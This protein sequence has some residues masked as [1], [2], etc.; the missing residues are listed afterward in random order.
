MDLTFRTAQ[1]SLTAWGAP[2]VAVAPTLE[3]HAMPRQ[4]PRL[5]VP[6]VIEGGPALAA[7]PVP[8]GAQV[9]FA[10]FL[11]GT[12]HSR[13][14]TYVGGVPVVHATVA[15]VV[16][17]RIDRRM[18]THGAGPIVERAVYAPRALLPEALWTV[19]NLVDTGPIE[20]ESDLHPAALLERAVHV[21]QEHRE[22]VERQLAERWCEVE[23]APL[24]IDGGLAKSERVATASQA[25]GVVK[26]HRT[27]YVGPGGLEVVCGLAEGER[28]TVFRVTSK[29]RTSVRSWY[30]RMR[31]PA[32]RGPLWGLVRVEV[33]D[34]AG[35]D[36]GDRADLVSRWVLA[37]VAPLALPDS[38][39]DTL[40]YG[41]RDC[42]EFLRAV[43]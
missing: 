23:R 2:G 1:R 4:S 30:L 39:W 6:E 16:R 36:P 43:V 3:V 27:M 34:L 9:G 41:V 10:A 11:D 19:V 21:V 22:R 12:Q 32:G 33:A 37:E 15:A 17:A 26:S 18:V 42:E 28:T 38:R 13:V 14:L 8:G 31:D 40:V 7:R 25:V 20:E 24:W 29:Q 35:E 5:V